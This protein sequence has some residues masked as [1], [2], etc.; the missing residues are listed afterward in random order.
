MIHWLVG[1]GIFACV[2]FAI[3]LGRIKHPQIGPDEHE[4][5]A[6]YGNMVNWRDVE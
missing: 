3:A 5:H 2:V 6:G 1:L 4:R